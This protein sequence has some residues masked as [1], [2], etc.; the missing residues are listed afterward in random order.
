ML[1]NYNIRFVPSARRDLVRMKEYILK[2]FKYLQYAV[3]FDNKIREAIVIIKNSPKSF[4]N[5]GLTYKGIDIYM[6][7][8]KSYLFFY[9]VVDAN[10]SVLRVFKDRMNWEY[11]INLWIKENS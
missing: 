7:S 11:I 4:K 1:E 10:I 6:K 3:N 8:I 5:T 9:V 2:E